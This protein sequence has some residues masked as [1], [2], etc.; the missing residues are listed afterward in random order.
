M[1]LL[2]NSGRVETLEATGRPLGLLRGI[3]RL[4]ELLR[5]AKGSRMERTRAL[6]K[7]VGEHRTT[8]LLDDDLTFL[9]LEPTEL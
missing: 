3:P 7:A 6:Y 9:V 8:S 2:R 4:A 1:L 5:G